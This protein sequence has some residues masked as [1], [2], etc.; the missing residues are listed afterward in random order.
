MLALVTVAS[1]PAWA[2][3]TFDKMNNCKQNGHD[4]LFLLKIFSLWIKK[5][6]SLYA[7]DVQN[8]CTNTGKKCTLL[9]HR[10]FCIYSTA[11]MHNMYSVIN[12]RAVN[13][14][15]FVFTTDTSVAHLYSC[16]SLYTAHNFFFFL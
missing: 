8:T 10:V 14:R 15:A 9:E 2:K 1:E 3:W 16:P 7:L 5:H 6:L 12:I 13:N 11:F 4:C